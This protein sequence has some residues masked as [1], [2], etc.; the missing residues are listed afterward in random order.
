MD[1]NRKLAAATNES[2]RD[3]WQNKC[4]ALE[5]AIDDAVYSLYGLS[6]DEIGLIEGRN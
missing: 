6:P 1:A 2:D 5:Q 4:D 3:F